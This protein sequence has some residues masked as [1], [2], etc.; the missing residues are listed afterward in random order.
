MEVTVIPRQRLPGA[1]S[2]GG[3]LVGTRSQFY[4]GSGT[5]EGT[6]LMATERKGKTILRWE[7][8]EAETG[9]SVAGV[10]SGLIEGLTV[11][12]LLDFFFNFF[13]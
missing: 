6:A 8:S 1:R 10:F 11:R 5:C 4:G 7:G 2:S 13:S 9:S 12:M 3:F